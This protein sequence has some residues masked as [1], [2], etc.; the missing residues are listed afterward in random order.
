[1]MR[2]KTRRWKDEK[3]IHSRAW[4]TELQPLSP[5]KIALYFVN[6]FP[7]WSATSPLLIISAKQSDTVSLKCSC[8]LWPVLPLL[9]YFPYLQQRWE[10]GSALDSL[11]GPGA[12][13]H[14]RGEARDQDSIPVRWPCW[15][16]DTLPGAERAASFGHSASQP[17]TDASQRESPLFHTED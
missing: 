15:R 4:N 1:M 6:S 13:P 16:D 5:P 12:M 14:R 3:E 11:L 10:K 7:T 9:N 8:K 2:G 17:T